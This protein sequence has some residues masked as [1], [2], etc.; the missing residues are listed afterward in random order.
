MKRFVVKQGVFLC[1]KV[2]IFAHVFFFVRV[3]CLYFCN[4]KSKEM[5]LKIL[6]AAGVVALVYQK[7]KASFQKKV[8]DLKREM[9]NT[10]AYT[11]ATI[12]DLQK[13]SDLDN[14]VKINGWRLKV[15]SIVN[16]KW[17][18]ELEVNLSNESGASVDIKDFT[19]VVDCCEGKS[20][21]LLMDKQ[22]TI[23]AKTAKTIVACAGN[24]EIFKK[25][26]RERIKDKLA[27]VCGKKLFTSCSGNS[28]IKGYR[29]PATAAM[30]FNYAGVTTNFGQQRKPEIING[31]VTYMGATGTYSKVGTVGGY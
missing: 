3:F 18:F 23:P 1:V 16:S 4:T 13:K 11:Q 6:T 22:I 19:A 20:K 15:R 28:K 27:A 17:N 5:N 14:Y 12:A 26:T 31:G 29:L 30:T 25:E 7:S 10:A 21:N 2:G 9:Q 24:D 8:D